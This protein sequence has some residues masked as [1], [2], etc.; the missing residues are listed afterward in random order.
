VS[1]RTRVW[2]SKC[3]ARPLPAL[4]NLWG[5]P[6]GATTIW[7]PVASTVP[8]PTVKVSSPSWTTNTSAWGWGVQARAFAG[9]RL[10]DEERHVCGTVEV[11]LEA[12]GAPAVR[13]LVFVDHELGH[14]LP[15]CVFADRDLAG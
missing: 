6:A 9:W 8:S 7:P 12:M 2:M 5:V 13:K 11:S 3:L 10:R 1:I 4:V 14:A 15:S